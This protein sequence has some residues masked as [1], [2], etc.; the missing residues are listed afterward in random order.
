MIDQ[1]LVELDVQ[2]DV[3]EDRSIL[4]RRCS[5]SEHRLRRP[6]VQALP[7]DAGQPVRHDH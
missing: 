5:D 3:Q 4:G 7:V 2:T 1:H 6:E